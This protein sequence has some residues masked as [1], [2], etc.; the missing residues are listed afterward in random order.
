VQPA[1]MAWGGAAMLIAMLPILE[2]AGRVLAWGPWLF[3]AYTTSVVQWM[4]AWPWA[5]VAISRTGGMWL[6]FGCAVLLAVVWL[7]RQS[8]GS[9]RRIATWAGQRWSKAA[10][11][12][13][14][15]VVAILVWLA[16]LQ[17]PDDRLH[18]AVLDVGQG[19]AILVTTPQGQQIVVDG[20]PSPSALLSA[21]GKKMPFWDRSIDLLVMTHADA[22]HVTGLV[23][24]LGRYEV[25]AWLDNRAAA[26][27]TL[28]L[29][30]QALMDEA[31]MPRLVARAGQMFS[32]GQG[33]DMEVLHPPDRL[34]THTRADDNNNSVV[35]RL[36]WGET[37]FL[38]TGDIEA[39][40]EELLLRS[41]LPLQ[42]D[43]LKVAHHGSGGSS[44]ANFLRE[45][46]PSF[47]A[48]SVG[49][50]NLAGH[51]AQEVLERLA[52]ESGAIVLRTD[53]D[54]TIEFITDGRQVWVRTE[55]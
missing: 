47:A 34:M 41:G 39:E 12:G 23:E 21:L 27:D 13:V 29:E 42:A 1:I 35:L 18:V 44:T 53:E 9:A 28:Y 45:V 5:S 51:P 15:V 50:E 38:L 25:D 49:A 48:I 31:E 55:R 26:N 30:C 24:V 19:D 7:L 14:L 46:D 52:E 32:L 3:L 10:I 33:I 2:V 6:L 54:G 43:V 37:S 20:G 11:L 8:R 40:A 16:V 4:A 22:D 36:S 17:L